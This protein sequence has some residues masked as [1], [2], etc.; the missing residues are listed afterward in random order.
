[1]QTRFTPETQKAQRLERTRAERGSLNIANP[2]TLP[3]ENCVSPRD[4]FT[5][6][7]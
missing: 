5:W 6:I 7:R 1:M 4:G 3:F 2:A